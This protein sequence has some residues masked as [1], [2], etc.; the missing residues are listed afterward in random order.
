MIIPTAHRTILLPSATL[1]YHTTSGIQVVEP[2]VTYFRKRRQVYLLYSN[3]WDMCSRLRSP[4]HSIGNGNVISVYAHWWELINGERG[5]NTK[6]EGYRAR[7]LLVDILFFFYIWSCTS[8][9]LGPPASA[10][11]SAL[12][13]IFYSSLC[14]L[15]KL[16]SMLQTLKD[17]FDCLIKIH[18][19]CILLLPT[20]GPGLVH[21][22]LFLSL[23]P[24]KERLL[25]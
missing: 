17:P 9:A 12:S 5:I 20:D 6:R 15:Q 22:G 14:A 19:L 3:T 18:Q 21:R 16:A 24:Q 23:W 10:S 7:V 8:H 25:P 4:S 2:E 13:T 1:W 11:L